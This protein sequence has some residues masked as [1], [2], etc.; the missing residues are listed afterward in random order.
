MPQL[1]P[2][3]FSPQLIWLAITFLLLY[4]GLSRLALPRVEQ[5]LGVRKAR[6]GGDIE[7]ARVAQAQ[8]E[9]V[10]ARYEAD[11]ASA[12]SKGQARIRS[13]REALDRELGDKRAELDRQIAAR[14]SEAEGAIA[15][16]VQRAAGEMEAA[17]ADVVSDILKQLAGIE[18]TAEEVH[19]ALRQIAKE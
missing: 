3:D 2:A 9:K 15:A 4:V 16:L 1:Q 10:M 7:K 18:A 12:K 19:A 11:I 6:I 14:G 8:S 13:S 5:V 17:T